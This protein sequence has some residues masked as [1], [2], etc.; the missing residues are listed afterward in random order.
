MFQH[1]MC[2][3]LNPLCLVIGS[4]IGLLIKGASV[5]GVALH[6]VLLEVDQLEVAH[7]VLRKYMKPL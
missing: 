4:D 7:E 5:A 1:Q 2:A 3:G 6:A